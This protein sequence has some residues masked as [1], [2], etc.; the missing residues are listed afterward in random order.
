LCFDNII[1][2]MSKPALTPPVW[3]KVKDIERGS[4]GYNVKVRV[5]KAEKEVNVITLQNGKKLTLVKAVVG[6]ETGVADALFKLENHEIVSEG[7]VIAIR[8]GRRQI[9]KGH[10]ML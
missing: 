2:T 1:S 10:I 8:N 9:V 6:D 7:K 3:S 4:S 5:V